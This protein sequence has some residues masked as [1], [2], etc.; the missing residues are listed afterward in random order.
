MVPAV[1]ALGIWCIYL[2]VAMPDNQTVWQ[3]VVGQL[4]HT[5]SDQNPQAWWFG[6]LVALPVF[7]IAFGFAYLLNIAR[8]RVRGLALFAG[9]IALAVATFLLTNWALGVFVA[10]PALWG[11]RAIHA[12]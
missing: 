2:F 5:F 6:W 10:L 7:C 8:T 3:S 12:T 4:Q 9:T 1:F 11:Y